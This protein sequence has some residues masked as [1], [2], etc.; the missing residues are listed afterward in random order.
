VNDWVLRKPPSTLAQ[1]YAQLDV[2]AIFRCQDTSR[3]GVHPKKSRAMH[4]RGMQSDCH[5]ET[6]GNKGRVRE[7]TTKAVA[8]DE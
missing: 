7:K 3:T 8:G 4:G 2:C 1:A 6:V 5:V